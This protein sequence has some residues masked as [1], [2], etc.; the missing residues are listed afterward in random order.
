[1]VKYNFPNKKKKNERNEKNERGISDENS[2]LMHLVSTQSLG[3]R[4]S[5]QKGPT[6]LEKGLSHSRKY[7]NFYNNKCLK[8]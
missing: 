5:L 6:A 1:M 8:F 2:Q 7:P 3:L 4:I